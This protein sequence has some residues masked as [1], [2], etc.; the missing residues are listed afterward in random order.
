M[1]QALHTA[2][3]ANDLEAVQTLALANRTILSMLVRLAYD[4]TSLIGWRA[5]TAIGIVSSLFVNNNYAFLRDTVR[6]LLW[7]LSDE[8]GGIGW[9][10]PE[11]LGEIVSADPKKFYDI[12][13]L[14]AEVYDIEE[15]VFRPGI[16]YALGKIAGVEPALVLPYKNIVV[17]G[18]SSS[19]PL[20]RMYALDLAAKLK[21]HLP[22]AEVVAL[23]SIIRELTKDNAEVW[24]YAN[25]GFCGLSIADKAVEVANIFNI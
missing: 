20:A 14:I 12:V 19:D 6:K 21:E 9:S 25:G 13:P 2:L 4:K 1:K 16:L 8:S 18:L 15:K 22:H 10:S 5:I 11:I 7:S 3:E 17:S 23:A 24:I